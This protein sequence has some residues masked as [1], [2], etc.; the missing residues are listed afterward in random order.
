MSVFRAP[1]I[2]L[3]PDLTP[4]GH[5]SRA[6]GIIN[7]MGGIGALLALSGAPGST[8]KIRLTPS[9]SPASPSSSS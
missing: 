9:S 7:F 4:P 8:A 2:A 1:T 5:R 3:M 6:N